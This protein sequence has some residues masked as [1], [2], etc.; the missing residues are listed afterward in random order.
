MTLWYSL[1]PYV[2]GLT[3]GVAATAQGPIT[4]PEVIKR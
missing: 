1:M 3:S 2:G 4:L